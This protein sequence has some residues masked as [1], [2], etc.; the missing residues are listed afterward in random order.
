M[1]P[2]ILGAGSIVGRVLN[3]PRNV[4]AM[5][6]QV[7]QGQWKISPRALFSEKSKGTVSRGRRKSSR[8]I[9]A[10]LWSKDLFFLTG[11]LRSWGENVVHRYQLVNYWKGAI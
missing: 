9:V 4:S 3:L 8:K 11:C 6:R 2:S 5:V 7:H 10:K 1:V